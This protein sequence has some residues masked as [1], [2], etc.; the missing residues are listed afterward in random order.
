MS[1]R[2][3]GVEYFYGFAGWVVF[4]LCE[5]RGA[6]LDVTLVPGHKSH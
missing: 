1:S 3:R 2:G 4:L 5:Q 6:R